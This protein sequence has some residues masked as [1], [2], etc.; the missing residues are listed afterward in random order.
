MRAGVAALALL[1]CAAPPP[2]T[3][4]AAPDARDVTLPDVRDATLVD[5]QDAT[6]LDV[7]D[8]T[9]P[10]VRDAMLPDVRDATPLDVQDAALTDAVDGDVPLYDP[11]AAG[12]LRDLDALGTRVGAATTVLGDNLSAGRLGTLDAP[13]AAGHSGYPVVYR[14]TPRATTRLRVSTNDARTDA[15][16]D[17]VVYAMTACGP[18]ADGGA[19]VIGCSDDSGDPPRDHATLFVTDEDV[20]AGR[21]V[22]VVVAGFLHATSELFDAQGHFALTVTEQ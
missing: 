16:L 9:L 22:Y 2:A 21:P 3:D 11:C 14:Y 18:A 15:R 19:R 10:D 4:A 1:G 6:L 13:C 7:Q 5:V 17:T 12:R 8:A 20:T